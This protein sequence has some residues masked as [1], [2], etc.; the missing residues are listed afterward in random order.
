M[1]R[2]VSRLFA[3]LLSAAII[4]SGTAGPVSA[5]EQIGIIWQMP[6]EPEESEDTSEAG[7]P[8][9]TDRI[10]EDENREESGGT[11]GAGAS[12]DSEDG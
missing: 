8:K 6:E 1:K 10:P 3:G 7:M 12:E 11:P 5:R 9:E 2:T 4:F